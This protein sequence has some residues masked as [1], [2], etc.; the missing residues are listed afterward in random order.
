MEHRAKCV[1]LFFCYNYK[2]HKGRRWTKLSSAFDS[3]LKANAF[4]IKFWTL[5]AF[6]LRRFSVFLRIFKAQARSDLKI[7]NAALEL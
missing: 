4:L 3:T 2:K 7:L 6:A 5:N 1:P